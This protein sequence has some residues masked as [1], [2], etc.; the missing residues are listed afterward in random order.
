MLYPNITY[1]VF[2]EEKIDYEVSSS[3]LVNTCAKIWFE[4]QD[5]FKRLKATLYCIFSG[6][7]MSIHWVSFAVVVPQVMQ[8]NKKK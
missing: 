3:S 6:Q 4:W 5:K 8:R 7:P 2:K 1:I